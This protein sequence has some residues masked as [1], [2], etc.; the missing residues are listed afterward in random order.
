MSR[1]SCI[2][3]GR[4]L[5]LFPAGGWFRRGGGGGG[6]TAPAVSKSYLPVLLRNE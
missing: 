1:R 6:V 2:V 3:L 5:R 4:R